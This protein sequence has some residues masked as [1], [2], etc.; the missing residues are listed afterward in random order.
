MR[1]L[2]EELMIPVENKEISLIEEYKKLYI[3]CD[4]ILNKI[5]ERK[6]NGRKDLKY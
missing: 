1:P 5:K 2:K 4:R 6:Q 3:V